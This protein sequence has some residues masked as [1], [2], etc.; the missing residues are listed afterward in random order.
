MMPDKKYPKTEPSQDASGW[1]W[2]L[3]GL[4]LGLIIAIAIYLNNRVSIGE[5]SSYLPN[6][7]APED[8]LEPVPE[9]AVVEN[10]FTF[11]TIL[12]KENPQIASETTSIR[13]VNQTDTDNADFYILQVGAFEISA[14]AERMRENLALLNIESSLQEITIDSNDYNRVIIG[15]IG[16]VSELNSLQEQLRDANIDFYTR[17]RPD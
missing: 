6:Q 17:K 8:H 12:P 10:P 15:P 3:S 1:I 4:G 2:M 7:S 13:V 9:V 11:Y 14:D 5:V 16:K